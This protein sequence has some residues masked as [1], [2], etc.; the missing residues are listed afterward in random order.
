MYSIKVGNVL[1]TKEIFNSFVICVV[2]G[3][4]EV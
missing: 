2:L 4:V 3:P 1:M